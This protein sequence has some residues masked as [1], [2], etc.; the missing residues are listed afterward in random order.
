MVPIIGYTNRSSARP[1]EQVEVKVSSDYDGS[2]DVDFVQILSADPNPA[3][4]GV[5]YRE[6][7]APFNGSYPS[8]KQQVRTG[9]YGVVDI[10][11]GTGIGNGW[12]FSVR[13]QPWLLDEKYQTVAVL[14]MQQSISISISARDTVLALPSGLQVA[15][16]PMFRKKWYELRVVS[17]GAKVSFHQIPLHRRDGGPVHKTVLGGLQHDLALQRVV[18][19]AEWDESSGRYSRFFNGRLEDPAILTST[20][21]TPELLDLECVANRSGDVAHWW[22]FSADIPGQTLSDR[23][24]RRAPGQVINLPTR[25][26]CGSRWSGREMNWTQAPRDYAAIHFH[27]DDLYDSGWETDFVAT[28]PENLASGVY[29]FRLRCGRSEDVIPLY[30]LPGKAAPKKAVALL[31]PTFTYQVYA[32]FDRANFDDAYRARRAEWG[33]YPHHPAEHREYGYSTYDR[34]RDGSGVIYSSSRRPVLTDRPGYICYVDRKGSGIRHLSADMHIV[35]WMHAS[36]IEFDVITDHDLHHEGRALLQDYHCVLTGTH[37]EYHTVETLDALQAYIDDGG[38]FVYL[39]GN[40]FYWKLGIS[41]SVPDV[42]EVRRAE[43]GTRA[44]ASDPGEYYHALDGAFGGL[45]RRNRRP[46]QALVGVGMTAQGYFEGTYYRRLPESYRPDMAWMFEGIQDEL[47][48]DFG[49]SGGGA[50]GFELDRADIELG[51]PVNAVVVARSEKHQA[52][53][54]VTPEEVLSTLPHIGGGGSADL[55][56]ADMTYFETPGGGAV[57]SVGSITFCGSLSHNNYENNISQLLRNVVR[58][59][60]VGAEVRGER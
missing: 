55:I 50:A 10:P 31:V 13:V 49:L 56:R 1:G 14:V 23:G 7:A 40:G 53:F 12:T 48:G 39:G 52:H 36:G 46:P 41:N 18:L 28:I 45:W 6:M 16:P 15:L 24:I 57:F 27:E 58:R 19:A 29:G 33:G 42:L 44:W 17:D 9:S 25:A 20:I 32:N 5:R 21:D 30:V 60:A 22:D 8:R 47:L 54:G 35:E 3:S 59:F 26:V 4:T 11:G 43:A 2:Y 37:P 51:T 38:K 34:H